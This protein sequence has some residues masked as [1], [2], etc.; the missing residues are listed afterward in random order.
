[1]TVVDD[2]NSAMIVNGSWSRVDQGSS[3]VLEIWCIHWI[4]VQANQYRVAE[5]PTAA[6]SQ[7]QGPIVTL[8]HVCFEK[9]ASIMAVNKGTK[10]NI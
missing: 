2:G 4:Q 3:I 5:S 1:V 10:A 6:H 8:E 9:M 7:R